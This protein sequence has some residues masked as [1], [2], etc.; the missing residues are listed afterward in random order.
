MPSVISSFEQLANARETIKA[1][2]FTPCFHMPLLTV[3]EFGD[4]ELQRCKDCEAM[5]AA[6]PPPPQVDSDDEDEEAKEAKRKKDTAWA[7]WKDEHEKGGGN[8][9][10]R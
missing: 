8:R 7:D 6:N 2:V 3:E 1:K 10:S 9:V 4:I 5:R